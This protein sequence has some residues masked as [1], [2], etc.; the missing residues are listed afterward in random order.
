MVQNKYFLK[1]SFKIVFVTSLFFIFFVYFGHPAWEKFKD[2][3]TLI[4]ER[5]VTKNVTNPPAITICPR[6]KNEGTWKEKMPRNAITT[7]LKKKCRRRNITD[8]TQCVGE[9]G[10]N[11]T[12]T[13]K[14]AKTRTIKETILKPNFWME[15]LSNMINPKCHTLNSTVNFGSSFSTS[16]DIMFH[17]D[18]ILTTDPL[19]NYFVFIHD[20]NFIFLTANPQTT[21]K[22]HL[23]V[24]ATFG[25]KLIWIEE[26]AYRRL[27]LPTQPCKESLKYSFKKCV[28]NRIRDTSNRKAY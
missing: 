4:S 6:N 16:L 19:L 1:K 2:K 15:D 24:D 26:I 22:L 3:R 21:P 23:S 17:Q 28:Q 9:M 12:E 20:P 13:I 8:M 25:Y 14:H 5:S 18:E 7:S 11:L 27:N 10:Y